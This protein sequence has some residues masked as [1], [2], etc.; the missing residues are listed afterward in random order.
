MKSLKSNDMP[1]GWG[2]RVGKDEKLSRHPCQ[3]IML[4]YCDLYVILVLVGWVSI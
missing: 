4:T 2:E 1:V 3:E